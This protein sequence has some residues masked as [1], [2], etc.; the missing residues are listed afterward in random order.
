MRSRK[1]E[2]G[3]RLRATGRCGAE[4]AGGTETR[5]CGAEMADAARRWPMRRGDAVRRGDGR[6]GPERRWPVARSGRWRGDAAVRHEDGRRSER[7]N[8]KAKMLARMDKEKSSK[9]GTSGGEL[10]T[11]DYEVFLSF[12]GPDTR[13]GFTD[14]LYHE[15]QEANIRVFFDEEELHV[16]KEIAY[17]LPMAIEKSKI[18]VPIFSKGYVSSPWCLREL[19][20]MVECTNTKPSEKE[21]M[22]IFYNVKPF[23]VKLMSQLYVRDLKKHE[24]KFGRQM[25]LNWEDALKSVAKIKGWELKS[26]GHWKFIKSVIREIVMKLKTKDKYVTE[27]IVGMDDQVEAVLKLLDVHSKDMH[28]VLIHGMGGI[29]F[30]NIINDVDDGIKVIAQ[31]LSNKKV[32]IV[33]DDVDDEE[34]LKKLAIKHVSLNSGSKII[35]TTRKRSVL[36][37]N[38]TFEYEVKSLDSEDF[39][40]L[41]KLL[42][43]YFIAKT[44]PHG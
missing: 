4:M 21:I 20:H 3:A 7:A 42:A 16:G 18:Y 41:L 19:T 1:E 28:V 11:I 24:K 26:Q 12:R 9:A 44:K 17:E 40:W 6:C 29:G 5:R 13:Q 8:P 23:D 37:A 22:P 14:C 38:Q 35:I 27:H 33:L 31:R 32:F 2:G 36:K 10:S 39:H 34:Q 25:R 30:P 15:M 43:H